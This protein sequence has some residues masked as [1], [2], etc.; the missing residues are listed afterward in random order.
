MDPSSEIGTLPDQAKMIV[1]PDE[2]ENTR[3]RLLDVSNRSGYI[4]MLSVL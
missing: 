4:A 2:I 3:C 1:A